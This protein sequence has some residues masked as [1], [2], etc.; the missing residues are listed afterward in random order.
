MLHDAV[1]FFIIAITCCHFS[2][3][4]KETVFKVG[5]IVATADR[6]KTVCLPPMLGCA[7]AAAGTGGLIFPAKAKR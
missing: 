3:Q 7:F 1:L 6:T 4:T 2:Y 5:L